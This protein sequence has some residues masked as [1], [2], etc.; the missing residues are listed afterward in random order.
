MSISWRLKRCKYENLVIFQEAWNTHKSNEIL[1]CSER[2]QPGVGS[3]NVFQIK[4]RLD[5]FVA[6]CKIHTY[7]YSHIYIYKYSHLYIYKYSHIYTYKYSHLYS[8]ETNWEVQLKI[9]LSAG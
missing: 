6:V 2:T 1:N 7:K 8:A 3:I 4:K 5:A 9:Q